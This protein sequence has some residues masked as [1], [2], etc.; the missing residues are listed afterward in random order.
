M[1]CWGNDI[2]GQL[3]LGLLQIGNPALEDT[4]DPKSQS[5][6]PLPRF[7]TYGIT[8]REIS[9][10]QEHTAFITDLN[11]LYT[12][13]SN[14]FGQLGVGQHIKSKNSP[15][16][17]EYF[18]QQNKG[19]SSVSCGSN[20]TVITSLT[21]QVFTW[22]EGQFGALGVQGQSIDQFAP[23]MIEMP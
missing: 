11:Y 3:G 17:V 13:G 9:C 19:V 10:G 4:N 20:H 12:V 14:R 18:V 8:I 23:V 2:S 16:L 6:Q 7:C 15:V 21:G 22:G 5:K 1:F